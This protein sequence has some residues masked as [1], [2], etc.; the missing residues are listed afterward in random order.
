M[1][2]NVKPDPARS[3]LFAARV[4]V[5]ALALEA[6]VWFSGLGPRDLHWAFAPVWLAALAVFAARRRSGPAIPPPGVPAAWIAVAATVAFGAVWAWALAAKYRSFGFGA[7]DLGIYSSVAFNTAHGLPFFSSVQQ[8]NHLGEHF[9]PAMALFAPLYRLAPTP[10]WLLAAGLAAYLAVPP[11]L[12]RLARRHAPEAGPAFAATAA[13]LWLLNRPMAG[14]MESLFHPST[15][16]APLL[17]LAWHWGEERRWARFGVLLA[18]LL[19]FKENLSLAGAGLGLYF[20]ARPATRRA[21]LVTLAVSLGAGAAISGWVIPFFRGGAWSHTARLDPFADPLPKLLYAILLLLPFGFA[22]LRGRALLPALPAIALNLATGFRP[23]YSMANHYDDL[24]VPLLFAGLLGAAKEGWRPFASWPRPAALAAAALCALVSL[25]PSPCRIALANRPR[26]E[27]R[28]L[29]AEI[30]RLRADPEFRGM[31][32]LQ[33][34][35]DPRFQQT[36]K[37]ALDRFN[38]HT[39]E[40]GAWIVTS[41]AVDPWPDADYRRIEARFADRRFF[42]PVPDYSELRVFRL[43]S[44][45]AQRPAAAS[46]G[47]DSRGAATA[48][49]IRAGRAWSYSAPISALPASQATP[50]AVWNTP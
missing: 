50:N 43:R 16:A 26:P 9:S 39:A 18:A 49:A 23:Q 29:E 35:L 48:N 17:L 7:Y 37:A 13:V 15:L 21:G 28:R 32:Y 31:A 47:S 2:S 24:V 3:G 27:H 36:A 40:E 12:F 20:A 45:S 30:A 8:M 34:R 1:A 38:G 6:L 25:G 22:H 41:P 14:A 19:A 46:S 11:L 44:P 10:A 4:A 5:A 42:H 33:D